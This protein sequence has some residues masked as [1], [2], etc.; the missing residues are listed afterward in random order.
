MDSTQKLTLR[1]K[2]ISYEEKTHTFAVRLMS[3]KFKMQV[4]VGH[5][6]LKSNSKN[7]KMLQHPMATEIHAYAELKYL[8]NSD[9]SQVSVPS[10][11]SLDLPRTVLN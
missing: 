6:S 11:H 10:A 2:S 1:G 4:I 9:A 8:L 3:G 7:L 5:N